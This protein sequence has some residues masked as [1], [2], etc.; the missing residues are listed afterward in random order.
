[1]H[2]LSEAY[3]PKRDEALLKGLTHDEAAGVRG[4]VEYLDE[5]R[6]DLE[7]AEDRMSSLILE[8]KFN[9]KAVSEHAYGS[10][11]ATIYVD[12]GT[13]H[14]IDAKF[15]YRYVD[16]DENK[17]LMYYAIGIIDELQL[18]P[19]DVVLHIYQPFCGDDIPAGRSWKVSMER[20]MEYRRM[21]IDCVA[22]INSGDTEYVTGDHC[23]FC[24][25]AA[26]PKI[27]A[28]INEL[29]PSAPIESIEVSKFSTEKLLKMIS[30]E[31]LLTGMISDAK[32]ILH[33]RALDGDVIPGKKL[34]KAYGSRQWIHNFNATAFANS[35]GLDYELMYD[36]PKV[37]SAPSIEG[38]LKKVYPARKKE[39]KVKRA[40][41]LAIF[42]EK[43]CKPDN[44]VRL[45]DDSNKGEAVQP[46]LL[47]GNAIEQI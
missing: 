9:L 35:V 36:V 32:K 13:L 26:C 28:E 31:K 25:K 41:I 23:V 29:L 10:A 47:S 2:E 19:S 43:V 12:F 44:G 40:E 42:N 14:I 8:Q 20:L 30:A 3:H 17:Q 21:L 24:N 4:Y 16:A 34:V 6:L 18:N 5:L 46:T 27:E 39:D 11:D 45:V 38:I 15:G 7:I 22:K 1:L 37:L 33:H